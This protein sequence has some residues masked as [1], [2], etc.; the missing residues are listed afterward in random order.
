M[1]VKMGLSRNAL[2]PKLLPGEL[3]VSAKL[4]SQ[5]L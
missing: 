5:D 2:L 3:R 1:N 4:G